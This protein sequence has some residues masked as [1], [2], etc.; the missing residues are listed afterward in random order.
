MVSPCTVPGNIVSRGEGDD[1][2]RVPQL[3]AHGQD[4]AQFHHLNPL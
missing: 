4:V 2:C 1:D 3:E